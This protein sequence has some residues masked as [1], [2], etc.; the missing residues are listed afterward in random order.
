MAQTINEQD[1]RHVAKLA[2]LKLSDAEVARYAQQLSDVLGYVAKLDE[3]DTAGAEPMA[4]PIDLTNALRDDQPKVPLDTE[5]ALTNAPAS[6]PPFFKV[7][8][9]LGEGPGA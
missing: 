9:V 4:H 3:L 6:D 2:R 7:P 8:K 5:A 1:V